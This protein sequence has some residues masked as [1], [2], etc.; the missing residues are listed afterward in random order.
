MRPSFLINGPGRKIGR[1][2]VNRMNAHWGQGRGEKEEGWCGFR[3]ASSFQ[4]WSDADGCLL[5]RLSRKQ[6]SPGWILLTSDRK[7]RRARLQAGNKAAKLC[8]SQ[9]GNCYFLSAGLEDFPGQL[10]DHTILPPCHAQSIKNNKIQRKIY[11]R[12]L[13][14]AAYTRNSAHIQFSLTL[15][16]VHGWVAQGLCC[17]RIIKDQVFL[18]LP[19]AFFWIGLWSQGCWKTYSVDSREE[20]SKGMNVWFY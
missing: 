7:K 12:E 5:L 14:L 16:Q 18:T 8:R 1:C 10:P 15:K 17:H 3:A 20:Q 19:S 2:T 13:I 11:I 9:P 6:E 4:A